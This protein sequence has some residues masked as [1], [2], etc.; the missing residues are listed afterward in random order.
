LCEHNSVSN[1]VGYSADGSVDTTCDFSSEFE[2]EAG[3]S[4]R[5]K[6]I[7]PDK[8]PAFKHDGDVAY[9]C[10]GCLGVI[11]RDCRVEYSSDEEQTPTPTKFTFPD[12]REN[13]SSS[14]TNNSSSSKTDNS[15]SSKTDN[16]SLL[17]DFAD[18]SSEMPDYTGGD[19]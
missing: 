7:N 16:S 6:E 19:D 4:T 9:V 2:A 3:K 10:D 13:N 1:F 14:E 11:C 15:S 5:D 12:F 18:T 17:D 8:H